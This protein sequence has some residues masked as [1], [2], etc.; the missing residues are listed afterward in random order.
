VRRRQRGGTDRFSLKGKKEWVECT[1]YYSLGKGLT[2]YRR[3]KEKGD[4]GHSEGDDT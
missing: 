2:E 3:E 1:G 4:D